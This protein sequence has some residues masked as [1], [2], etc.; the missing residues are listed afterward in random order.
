MTVAARPPPTP[1]RPGVAAF[2][3][4]G[5]LIERD[6]L[7]PFLRRSCGTHRVV[8]ATLRAARH[9][10]NRDDLK[11]VMLRG[12]FRGWPAA[13]LEACG[14]AYATE[15]TARLRPEMVERVR[16]HRSRGHAVVIVSASLGAYLR[17]VGEHLGVDG[18]LAVEL[19]TDDSGILTGA[20]VG[21]V[22]TRGIEKVRRLRAWLDRRFGPG[23]EV[24]LWSYGDSSGDDELLAAADHATWVGR[25]AGRAQRG[26]RHR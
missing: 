15:L 8:V 23:G 5:T 25:H 11:V 16:W 9:A 22:N 6:T 21:G 7:V 2:D 24:E 1:D 12:L 19:T 17:P 3:F 4:D 20:V 13:D 14:R 10:R 18:V 26:G